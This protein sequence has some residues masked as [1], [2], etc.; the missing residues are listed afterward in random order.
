LV[1]PETVTGLP[2]E[3]V[4]D[5]GE[6][7]VVKEVIAEP[8]VALAEKVTDA[9]PLPAVAVPIVGACGTDADS[10]ELLELDA[11]DVPL[12]LVAVTVNVYELPTVREIVIGLAPP[13][14]VPPP[15]DVA[16][17]VETVLP[18]FAPAVNGTEM[19]ALPV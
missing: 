2:P 14:A 15:D 17:N 5:P 19:L 4:I 12:A 18:P 9:V 1:N 10:T 6:E 11:P 3:A 7:V 16:V 13:V 8:P